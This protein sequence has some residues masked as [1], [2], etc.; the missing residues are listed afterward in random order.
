MET[1]HAHQV[2]YV[3]VSIG[4]SHGSTLHQST[5]QMRL[6]DSPDQQFPLDPTTSRNVGDHQGPSPNTTSQNVREESSIEC[7]SCYPGVVHV[8]S[9]GLFP[10]T[11]LADK[12]CVPIKIP[13]IARFI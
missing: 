6:F 12:D 10:I 5:I 4:S 7:E 11:F 3:D 13:N 8:V 2:Q 9:K 1:T